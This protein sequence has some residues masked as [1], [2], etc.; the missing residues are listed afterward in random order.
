MIGLK[1]QDSASHTVH[2][3]FQITPLCSCNPAFDVTRVDKRF[4]REEFYQFYGRLKDSISR[5]R[6]VNWFCIAFAIFWLILLMF[7]E[8]GFNFHVGLFLGL[9]AIEII[10]LFVSIVMDQFAHLKMV[11]FLN[12]ENHTFWNIRAVHWELTRKYKSFYYLTCHIFIRKGDKYLLHQQ[13]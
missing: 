9:L 3:T 2:Y 13:V 7:L 4:T 8:I 1:I 5:E 11:E 12:V 6:Q 10:P